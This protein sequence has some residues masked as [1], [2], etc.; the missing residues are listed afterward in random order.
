MSHADNLF[1]PPSGTGTLLPAVRLAAGRG[2][3]LTDYHLWSCEPSSSRLPTFLFFA[4]TFFRRARLDSTHSLRFMDFP[5]RGMKNPRGKDVSL[6][7]D[8]RWYNG[9]AWDTTWWIARNR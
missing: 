1:I 6:E 8:R 3:R 9:R 2:R 5:L 4:R 7:E